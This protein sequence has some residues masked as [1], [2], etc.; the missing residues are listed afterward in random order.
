MAEHRC[1]QRRPV[2]AETPVP[3]QNAVPMETAD[4]PMNRYISAAAL[5]S[6]A[7]T[8]SCEDTCLTQQNRVLLEQLV[9][10]SA[11]QNQILLD[12]L[13]AV[14]SLTAALLTARAQI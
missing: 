12:L 9:E 11:Q 10:L 5:S 7:V 14:N 2:R 3:T 8:R 4:E 1:R 13:G 6:C